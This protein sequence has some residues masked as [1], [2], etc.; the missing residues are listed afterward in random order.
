MAASV[1]EKRRVSEAA[2]PHRRRPAHDGDRGLTRAQRAERTE[3]LL[4]RAHDATDPQE[5]Q[6]LLDE[7]VLI[8]RGVAEAVASRYRRRGIPMEDLQQAAYEGLVK[9]VNRF[10][11][12]RRK[13]LLTYAVPTMRGELQRHFRD[14]GWTV[15]PPRRV[16]ELQWQVNACIADLTQE[17][18]HEPSDAEV[19]ERLQLPDD[20]YR[21]AITAFGCFQPTSLDQPLGHDSA[22]TLGDVIP[23]QPDD[24]H[25]PDL[26]GDFEAADARATLGPAVRKLPPRDRRILYL[27]FFEDQTQEEIGQELGVTQMQVSRLLARILRDL[28]TAI[29]A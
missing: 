23:D 21:D 29:A 22:A 4:L 18:G 10:D 15:R 11:P 6:R 2:Q 27:R 13:D 28:R 5:R 26:P 25:D 7:V 8:N 19:Q 20:E 12:T 3:E 16:Q 1:R 9:A 24:V 14:H 17:L